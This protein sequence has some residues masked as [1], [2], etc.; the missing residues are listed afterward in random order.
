MTEL[1]SRPAIEIPFRAVL[2]PHRSLGPTG[3][4][5][6][7]VMVSAISFASG[8]MFFMLGAW[9][10]V[11]FLGLDVLLLYFAFRISFRSLTSE[12][13]VEVDRD[14]VRVAQTAASGAVARFEFNPLWVRLELIE[15]PVGTADLHLASGGRRLALGRCL[16]DPERRDFAAALG[17]ALAL[18]RR[19]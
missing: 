3:F 6:L 1:H 17:R 8:L 14:R 10:V 11:G 19:G 5:V 18:A 9:P 15:H 12:E 7:M 2:T 4:A 13:T 16:S